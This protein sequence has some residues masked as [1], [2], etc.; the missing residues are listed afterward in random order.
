LYYTSDFGFR[1]VTPYNYFVDASFKSKGFSE[2]I[3]LT[4]DE[5]GTHAKKPYTNFRTENI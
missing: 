3:E 1:T 5:T 2:E 4:G